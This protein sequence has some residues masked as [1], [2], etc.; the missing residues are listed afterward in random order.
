MDRV[1]LDFAQRG[2]RS[3]PAGWA[4]LL[5]G[6]VSL[7]AVTS[8]TTFKE[9]PRLAAREARLDALKTA[10]DARGPSSVKLDDKQLVADWGRAMGVVGELNLPW[11][12]LF[13]TL[14][15]NANR[16]VALL[17]LEPDAVKH[18]LVLTAEAKNFDE[19]LA[20]YRVLQ[21]QE[22]FRSVTLHTHQINLQDRD[23]P[24]RFRITA[25][26]ALKS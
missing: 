8:W 1:I 21:Q 25:T 20:Y 19:M 13:T 15:A 18:E 6:A 17:S 9:A 11:D 4:L 24:I 22:I 14:E 12:K 10:L 26:W 16:P 5:L 2:H 3:G 7:A 23:K